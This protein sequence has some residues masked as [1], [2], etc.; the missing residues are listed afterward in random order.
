MSEYK[1]GPIS[2]S[3][4]AQL[5]TPET[6]RNRA[7]AQVRY[8]AAQRTLGRLDEGMKALDGAIPTLEKL[9]ADGDKSEVTAIGLASRLRA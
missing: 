8:G 7:L 1:S 3:Y 9:R 2:F 6:D 5:R 4:G